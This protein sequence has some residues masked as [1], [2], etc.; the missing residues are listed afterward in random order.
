LEMLE[1]HEPRFPILLCVLQ[2]GAAAN[3]NPVIPE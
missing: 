3:V 2:I 1:P